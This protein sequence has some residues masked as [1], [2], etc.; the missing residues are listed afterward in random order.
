MNRLIALVFA[1]VIAAGVSWAAGPATYDSQSVANNQ[2]PILGANN[3]VTTQVTVGTGATLLAP[4]RP[5]RISV[6]VT[7]TGT[8]AV[9]LGASTVTVS[10]GTGGGYLAGVAGTAK[11]LKFSGPVYGIAGAS[12]LVTIEEFF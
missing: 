2:V 5:G 10:G 1:F 3:Y 8:N 9:Y 11:E 4:Y 12:Q 6:I 7:Q